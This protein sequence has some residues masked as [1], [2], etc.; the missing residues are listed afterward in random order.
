MQRNKTELID[1]IAK[2]ANLSKADAGRALNTFM[3]AILKELN[4]GN[5]VKLIV[6]VAINKGIR[7]GGKTIGA[8]T[9]TKRKRPGR[10][11]YS[12]ITL[13]RSQTK[14]DGN[15]NGTKAIDHNAS[16]SNTTASKIDSKDDGHD[17]DSDDDGFLD[18]L[19][20]FKNTDNDCDDKDSSSLKRMNKAELVD[21]MVKDANLSKADAGK[22][23][24]S[25]IAII[26]KELNTG[27]CVKL[28]V[29]I[30]FNKGIREGGKTIG[31]GTNTKRKRP[32]RTKYSN[33]TL[34]R[35]QVKGDGNNGTKAIDHNA[36]RSNTTASKI[37]SKGDGSDENNGTKI[38]DHNASRSNTTASKIDSK[39]DGNDENNGTKA[40]NHNASRSNTTASKI[41]SK[42]DGSDENNGTKAINHNASRSNTTASKID[43]K[44]DGSDENNGTKIID[45]NASRS[46]TT[47]S[48]ID[49]KGDGNGKILQGYT[50]ESTLIFVRVDETSL[51][52]SNTKI[53]KD[54]F[55]QE[56]DKRMS[57]RTL[58]S[59]KRHGDKRYR[60]RTKARTLRSANKKYRERTKARTLRSADKRYRE[61]TKART[62]R[63]A[64]KRY[65]E[66]H[67]RDK[68]N[69]GKSVQTTTEGNNKVNPSTNLD[70]R[71]LKV[72]NYQTIQIAKSKFQL[73]APL[74]INTDQTKLINYNWTVKNKAQNKEDKFTG[75]TI[76]YNFD[77][78]GTYEIEITPAVNNKNLNSY[79]ITI[80][81]N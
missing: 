1:A 15:N 65:R 12:N 21:A 26:S 34:K 46:N 8:G 38:I 11:K 24:N 27:N 2:D 37:D 33:I 48:K 17:E 25:F 53:P 29:P 19:E 80:I 49:S 51:R 3:A 78:S 35:N 28:I 71:F 63:S 40:I 41:D 55:T 70:T 6:P 62:L 79:H 9:N 59:R 52:K 5:C 68:K 54:K 42:G 64:D 36:S 30:A 60:E 13:K 81:C 73:T 56:N 74:L 61:R 44:G 77:V 66:T 47:A 14:G 43:S 31:A 32:G 69:N 7:E 72:K 16:R 23:L 10:T 75:K 76:N 18:G 45:H 39:G 22:A 20:I 58:R 67:I 57:K 4:N 50:K